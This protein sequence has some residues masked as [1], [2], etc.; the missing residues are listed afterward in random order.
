MGTSPDWK[1]KLTTRG[2]LTWWNQLL[3]VSDAELSIKGHL[4]LIQTFALGMICA[5]DSVDI[6]KER[7][8]PVMQSLYRLLYYCKLH[9]GIGSTH[10]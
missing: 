5:T 1:F 4:A 7:H 8:P 10:I 6:A 2:I 3:V 9:F